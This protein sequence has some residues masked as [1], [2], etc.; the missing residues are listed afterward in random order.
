MTILLTADWHL[1]DQPLN[2]YRWRIFDH[3]ERW[4]DES[5]DNAL[6]YHLG[7]LT[8]R[9]D[10]HSANLVNE[11]TTQFKRLLDQGAVIYILM[12]NHDRPINGTPYWTFLTQ[13]SESLTFVTKPHALG[14]LLLLPYSDN[15]AEEWAHIPFKR[16]DAA[17]IH[18]TITGAVGNNG[19]LLD[20]P[21]MMSFPVKLKVYSGDIHTT[22]VVK[23]VKYVGAP[24]PVAFGDDYPCQMLELDDKFNLLR[25]IP[26]KTIQKLMLRI[27]NASELDDIEVHEGDQVR[28]VYRVLLSEVDYWPAMQDEIVAWAKARQVLLISLE[29]AIEATTAAEGTEASFEMES[30]PAYILRLFADAEQIDDKM[31]EVG[32][33]LLKEVIG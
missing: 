12:G 33:E 5:R 25:E 19:F 14:K 16:Y 4:M 17:F 24:H 13:M 29:P 15:P 6:I 31:F 3:I 22:Q 11:L 1:D 8:D 2:A 23:R 27:E 20:N 32:I 10:R 21:K 30:D 18:Q 7:D 28:V 26:C 9:K